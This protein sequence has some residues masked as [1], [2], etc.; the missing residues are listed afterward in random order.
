MK[1]FALCV[2]GSNILC[3]GLTLGLQHTLYSV[4]E[5]DGSLEV[6]AEVLEGTILANETVLIN[7]ITASSDAEGQYCAHASAQ[8]WTLATLSTA[9][10]LSQLQH[11]MTSLL[12]LAHFK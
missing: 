10:N 3:V 12:R 1:S 2:S 9:L 11:L 7:Y 6:C 8:Q 5:L 4:G